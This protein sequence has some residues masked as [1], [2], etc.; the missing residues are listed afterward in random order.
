MN[1]NLQSTKIATPRWKVGDQHHYLEIQRYHGYTDE[2]LARP[3]K[4]LSK[5]QHW[6]A[7]LCTCGEVEVVNQGNLLSRNACCQ[8]GN[9]ARS[10]AVSVSRM[11][12][13]VPLDVPD[14][15]RMKW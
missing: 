12:D 2:N 13:P 11:K 14:F 4:T 9:L 7:V 5:H 15:A 6:Y 8:C 10:R 1:L 3:G